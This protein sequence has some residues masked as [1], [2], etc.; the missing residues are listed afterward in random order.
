MFQMTL[1]IGRID[2]ASGI[3]VGG[4]LNIDRPV[5]LTVLTNS[6]SVDYPNYVLYE[7]VHSSIV[8]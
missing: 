3:S 1:F 8:S 5:V 7:R 6:Y 2:S 4:F